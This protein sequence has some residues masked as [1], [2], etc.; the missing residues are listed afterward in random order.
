MVRDIPITLPVNVFTEL[1]GMLPE[2]QK[3][4]APPLQKYF[5]EC[6]QQ[7]RTAK[8]HVQ[9]L[10]KMSIEG[11]SASYTEI[12][13][14]NALPCDATPWESKDGETR[15]TDYKVG[16]KAYDQLEFF[17]KMSRLDV[18]WGIRKENYESLQHLL[19]L[20]INRAAV[21][22]IVEETTKDMDAEE[23]ALFSKEPTPAE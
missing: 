6:L 17:G 1:E 14:S 11:K 13:A 10:G 2:Q 8:I 5:S 7:A 16:N 23:E 9:M 4:K 20:Q 19:S 21:G 12:E 15:T 22:K 3:G 18:I